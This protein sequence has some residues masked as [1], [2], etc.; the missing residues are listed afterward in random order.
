MPAASNLL[1][2]PIDYVLALLE[3]S[4]GFPKVEQRP[5]FETGYRDTFVH[6]KSITGATGEALDPRARSI[7]TLETLVTI[8]PIEHTEDRIVAALLPRPLF[9]AINDAD[10][11]GPFRVVRDH[12]F[13]G[14]ET[15]VGARGVRSLRPN[16]VEMER[17]IDT[18]G[19]RLADHEAIE[20]P[21]Q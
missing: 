13:G 6:A 17:Q 19:E 20:S 3:R 1:I 18:R 4:I 5:E 2:N 9:S 10:R 8:I 16:S 15:E 14:G 7:E 11:R 21:V 12:H